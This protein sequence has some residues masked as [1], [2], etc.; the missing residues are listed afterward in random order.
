M[1]AI[2]ASN[3]RVSYGINTY[4]TENFEE[5]IQY[6]SPSCAP[7]SKVYVINDSGMNIY[8]LTPSKSWKK[9]VPL[10]GGTTNTGGGGGNANIDI[11]ATPTKGSKNAVSSGG[12]YSALQSL[13]DSINTKTE[14]QIIDWGVSE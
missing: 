10:N 3:G 8:I 13:Q 9:F 14:V 2:I 5:D 7:G 4:L 11:D 6:V 12:V 1:Y